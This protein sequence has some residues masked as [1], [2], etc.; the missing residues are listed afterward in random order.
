MTWPAPD[1]RID[2]ANETVQQ[3]QHPAAHNDTNLTLN[4]DYR[5]EIIRLG[6]Q[7]NLERPF[8]ARETAT[9][10]GINFP[11]TT[12]LTRT[13]GGLLLGTYRCDVW[14]AFR[15]QGGTN[16]ANVLMLLKANGATIAAHQIASRAFIVNERFNIAATNYFT[17]PSTG[18]VTYTI[19]AETNDPAFNMQTESAN[20]QTR[21]FAIQLANS[22]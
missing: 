21:G 18:D 12:I 7:F 3:D 16:T 15:W 19:T 20:G 1:L 5:P 10:T 4:D 11:A 9:I 8:I 13:F 6:E 17:M 14:G 22:R 2:F